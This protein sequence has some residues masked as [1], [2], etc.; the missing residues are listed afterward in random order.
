MVTAQ[1]FL[2]GANGDEIELKTASQSDFMLATEVS[3]L[4]LTTLRVDIAE[5][6]GDGGVWRRTRRNP[7]DIDLPILVFGDGR[8]DIQ[9]KLRRLAQ[10]LSD[11]VGPTKLRID[12]ADGNSA[13]TYGHLTDGGS[14]TYGKD[15]NQDYCRWVITLRC[16]DPYWTS[17]DSVSFK[18]QQNLDTD[19]LLPYLGELRLTDGQGFGTVSISNPGEVEAFPTWLLTGPF[20]AVSISSGGIGFTYNATV[21]AGATITIDTAAGTVK[22]SAG[23]NLYGNLGTTPKLFSFPSGTTNLAVAVTN[24]TSATLVQCYFNP[25]HELVF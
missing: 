20:D 25:R 13:Y 22:S 21:A 19:G 18:V 8:A 9:V 10:I 16:P 12:F 23:A 6:A 7:R 5:G 4:G 15:A 17:S 1:V 2:V 11:R 3:G 24:P 14:T